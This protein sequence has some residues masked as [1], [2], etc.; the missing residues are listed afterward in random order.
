MT[1][2][3]IDQIVSGKNHVHEIGWKHIFRMVSLL[4]QG[5]DMPELDNPKID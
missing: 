1:P 5:C 2:Y 4:L 3:T